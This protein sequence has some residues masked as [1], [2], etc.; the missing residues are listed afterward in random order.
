MSLRRRERRTGVRLS[1]HRL[2]PA[3]LDVR[4]VGQAVGLVDHRAPRPTEGEVG[5]KALTGPRHGD[6]NV[7]RS[8]LDHL[9]AGDLVGGHA[10]RGDHRVAGNDLPSVVADLH[11]VVA[12]QGRAG[13][14]A[15][16]ER[17]SWERHPNSPRRHRAEGRGSVGLLGQR[18][19]AAGGG[20]SGGDQEEGDWCAH[21]VPRDRVEPL[22]VPFDTRHYNNA[23]SARRNNDL[24][25]CLCYYRT[26]MIVPP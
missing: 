10:R 6:R 5:I 20:E 18:G 9:L 2:V 1:S 21:F 3:L 22:L 19:A 16:H 23:M 26:S 11:G 14:P 8:D 15:H 4:A 17:C 24:R 7:G 25:G 13:A 12:G